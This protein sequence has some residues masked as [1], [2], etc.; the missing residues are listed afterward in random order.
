MNVISLMT[1]SELFAGVDSTTLERLRESATE[2]R[3]RRGDKLFEEND[4]AND[5]YIVTSGR[6]AIANKSIDGRESMVALM[7]GGDLFGEMPLFDSLGRS[8]EARALEQS[9]VV[10]VPYEPIR[11][12]Y[13]QRP[14]L[15][16]AVVRLLAGRLRNMDE[17]LADAVFLDVTGRT[18]KRLLELAGEADEFTLPITQEELA[19]MVGASRERV[20]KA[21]AAFIKLGGIQQVDRRYIITNRKQLEIRAR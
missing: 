20:N 8:A 19:G 3:L 17:A 15:L 13:E 7:E 12:L 11:A 18:A 16:W 4:V 14:E 21:I 5:L 1:K 2:H 9:V 10:S 6:I